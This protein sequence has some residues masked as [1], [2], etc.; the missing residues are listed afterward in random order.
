MPRKASWSAFPLSLLLLGM[1]VSGAMAASPADSLE[2]TIIY[3]GVAT[4][5]GDADSA[6]VARGPVGLVEL[7]TYKNIVRGK[8]TLRP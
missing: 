5:N 1:Q 4:A 7:T 8:G 2:A 6:S 3:Q